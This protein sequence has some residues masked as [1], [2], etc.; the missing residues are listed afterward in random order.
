M[1]K[2]DVFNGDADG[3]IA[4]HQ[5]RLAHPDQTQKVTGVKRDV[6][7]IRHL[8]EE[9]DAEV[10][11]F[12][13]SLESN[14][15]NVKSC[16][17]NGANFIWFDHHRRGEIEDGDQIKTFID[18]SPQCCTSLL[19]DQY[20]GSKYH[21]WAIAATFGD[22]LRA[23]AE[24][25]CE[26]ANLSEKERET[27]K[28]LG[29]TLNYNG[30]GEAKE[31]LNVWPADLYDSLKTFENPFDFVEQS[32]VFTKIA[33]QKLEDEKVLGESETLYESVVGNAVLLPNSPSSK[34]MSGIYSNDLVHSEPDKAHA[35]FTH[36]EG[37]EGFR[38]SIRAPLNNL[39]NADVLAKRFPTG[40]GRAGAAG[41]NQLPKEKLTEFFNAF[42]EI[43]KP[44]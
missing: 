16:L 7:L 26:A 3:I 12:D 25:L 2:F 14:E 34:R 28:D 43:F 35:I 38:I 17:A 18:L 9:M 5:F 1:P 27:L 31:D 37:E 30:Y 13:I 6:K 32:P 8:T 20:L 23:A 33:A 4:L 44:C 11:V 36:L 22:N 19:V 10:A 41:V 24:S 40:G 15:D 42:E 21:T 39:K 29:E